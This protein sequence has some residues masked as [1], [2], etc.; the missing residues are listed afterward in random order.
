MSSKS[1]LVRELH[2]YCLDKSFMSQLRISNRFNMPLVF[3]R[4]IA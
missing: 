3:T 4:V 1:L 2:D